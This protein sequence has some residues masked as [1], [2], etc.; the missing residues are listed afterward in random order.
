MH[1]RSNRV[2][3]AVRWLTFASLAACAAAGCNSK[4][5]GCGGSDY[6]AGCDGVSKPCTGSKCDCC[7]DSCQDDFHVSA[8]LCKAN[9]CASLCGPL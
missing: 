7:V 8:E 2:W 9:Q 1:K 4:S 6:T 3:R 5:S